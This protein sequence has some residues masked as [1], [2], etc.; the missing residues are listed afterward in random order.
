[1]LEGVSK[2]LPALMR[3]ERVQKKAAKAA[4][5]STDLPGAIAGV[6]EA[7]DQL[8]QA[9]GSEWGDRQEEELGE[10]LF[11][12]VQIARLQHLEAEQVLSDEC[13]R[14]IARFRESEADSANKNRL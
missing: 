13:D 4:G 9:V 10:L 3:S 5:E 6:K 14:F 8:G 7:A 1:M 12:A 2:A 11:S